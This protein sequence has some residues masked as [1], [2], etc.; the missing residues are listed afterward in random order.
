MVNKDLSAWT[1]DDVSPM[2]VVNTDKQRDG[3]DMRNIFM[4]TTADLTA[5]TSKKCSFTHTHV[6]NLKRPVKH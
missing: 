6:P 1:A 2:Q 3:Q 4:L 5:S